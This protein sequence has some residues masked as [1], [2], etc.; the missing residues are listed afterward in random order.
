MAARLD[1]S[2]HAP[3]PPAPPGPDGMRVLGGLL[4]L[5]G[6]P[7]MLL[8]A[9]A[10]SLTL[11]VTDP[12]KPPQPLSQLNL[13]VFHLHVTLCSSLISL[14]TITAFVELSFSDECVSS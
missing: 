4:G 6:L 9:T 11:Q 7:E 2:P 10:T 8:H 3:P 14:I 1:L 12:G 13:L 5:V